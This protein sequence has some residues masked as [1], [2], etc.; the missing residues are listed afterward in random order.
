M[1]KQNIVKLLFSIVLCHLAGFVGSFFTRPAIET[2]YAFL[3]KP[4]FAPPNWLF[5]PA[6]LTLYTLMG[7]A[8]YLVWQKGLRHKHVR[9]TFVLFLIHLLFNAFW[10]VAFFGLES[11]FWALIV[12]ALLWLFILWLIGLFSRVS[13]AA[14]Y[15]LIPYW[16]WV[17]FAAVLNFAIWQLN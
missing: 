15:L 2:W 12:I 9:R 16:L 17:S 3:E 7:V 11:P 13:K 10:S 8:L 14:A 6:W 5:A 1:T 4:D